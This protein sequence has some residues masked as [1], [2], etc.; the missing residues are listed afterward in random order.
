MAPGPGRQQERL[1]IAADL[2][3]LGARI[4]G[5]VESIMEEPSDKKVAGPSESENHH[6]VAPRFVSVV[7]GRKINATR[8]AQHATPQ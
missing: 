4:Y 6:G 2:S 8:N 5:V 3:A 1:L 7:A